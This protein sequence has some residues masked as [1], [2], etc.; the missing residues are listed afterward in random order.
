VVSVA[1]FLASGVRPDSAGRFLACLAAQLTIGQFYN[2]AFLRGFGVGVLNGS[3]W[4]IPVELQFYLLLPLLAL[5]ARRR[6][7][8]WVVLAVTACVIMWAARPFL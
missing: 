3:L 5:F 2:P 4:T 8:G 6:P 7:A 1:C